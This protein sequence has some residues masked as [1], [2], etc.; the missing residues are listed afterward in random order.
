MGLEPYNLEE[1]IIDIQ[2]IVPS[3]YSS[4]GTI[5][6]SLVGAIVY[7]YASGEVC[8]I[9]K[10]LG[11]ERLSNYS[12]TS[13]SVSTLP[14]LPDENYS[15]GDVV[16]VSGSTDTVFYRLS[17][18]EQ[19]ETIYNNIG[20]FL[21]RYRNEYYMI[22]TDS[23]DLPELQRVGKLDIR[24]WIS[25]CDNNKGN[26]P[27]TS[28]NWMSRDGNLKI[29]DKVWI[30]ITSGNIQQKVLGEVV[31]HSDTDTGSIGVGIRLVCE[32]LGSF[33]KLNGVK[34]NVNTMNDTPIEHEGIVKY[35]YDLHLTRN[36]AVA[37]ITNNIVFK[38][39]IN[40]LTKL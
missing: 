23:S 10:D 21:Y 11:W 22:Q 8:K 37:N 4:E 38:D 15:L 12:G 25:L 1:N 35:I 17:M 5:D 40:Y 32:E 33:V 30:M 16:G 28:R 36:N 31:K 14:E 13:T 24:T 34:V 6:S 27:G 2:Y 19:I 29:G 9:I 3:I 18:L 20:T 26:L 7:D 39:K